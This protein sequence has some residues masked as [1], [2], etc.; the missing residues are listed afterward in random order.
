LLAW[1]IWGAYQL[2]L[3]IHVVGIA[4]ILFL[5]GVEELPN[6]FAR[7][8][9]SIRPKPVS[10]SLSKRWLAAAII[11]VF[12]LTLLG[13]RIFYVSKQ[14]NIDLAHG[15]KM[16][17]Y[18]QFGADGE[19]VYQ[20]TVVA[21]AR[22]WATSNYN[23]G[24]FYGHTEVGRPDYSVARLDEAEV[25]RQIASFRPTVLVDGGEYTHG[26]IADTL[27]K[28]VGLCPAAFTSFTGPNSHRYVAYSVQ[29]D[30]LA[31]CLP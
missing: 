13:L 3:G 9:G 20:R 1:F 28:V 12:V 15:A 14:S 25:I 26:P 5:A 29:L 23:Y 16:A 18:G 30:E 2:R 6:R 10:L 31:H 22:V 17:L 8:T 11:T 7:H 24:I 19:V 27:H 4:A 21:K